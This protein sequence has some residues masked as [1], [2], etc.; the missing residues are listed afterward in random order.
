MSRAKRAAMHIIGRR[1]WFR[2]VLLTT[3]VLV[4]AALATSVLDQRP[5][6][7]GVSAQRPATS[8]DVVLPGSTQAIEETP[9]YTSTNGYVR[10]WFAE[11][12]AKVELVSCS[13]K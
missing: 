8:A 12:G 6:V 2:K 9:V 7:R 4:N 1:A 10:Q 13:L 11:I 5:A 3:L